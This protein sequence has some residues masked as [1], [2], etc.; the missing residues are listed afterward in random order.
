MSIMDKHNEFADAAAVTST[1]VLTNVIDLGDDSTL[2]NLGGPGSPYLVIQT[3]TSA[4]AAGAATVTFS[5][6]SDSTADLA[7]SAT[8]HYTTAAIAKTTLVA[9]YVAAVVQLPFGDYERYLGVR[10]TVGTGPLTAGA[11]SAFLTRDPQYW[12]AM[13]ANN[14]AAN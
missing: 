12:K 1:A 4:T 13:T 7:T 9:G 2:R 3:D 5:L 8:V 11:F 10:A 6:E 14:P